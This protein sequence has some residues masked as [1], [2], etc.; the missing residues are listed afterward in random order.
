MHFQLKTMFY[1]HP[2]IATHL[3]GCKW[4]HIV[5]KDCCCSTLILLPRSTFASASVSENA[6]G[7]HITMVKWFCSVFFFFFFPLFWW[8]WKFMQI[9]LFMMSN[10]SRIQHRS[11]IHNGCVYLVLSFASSVFAVHSAVKWNP[12]ETK[13]KSIQSERICV[14]FPFHSQRL[15]DKFHVERMG[16]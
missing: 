4:S 2:S 1:K 14:Q 13:Y 11:W 15:M 8:I 7:C 5:C 10:L 6:W 9:K 16:V 3:V 12:F